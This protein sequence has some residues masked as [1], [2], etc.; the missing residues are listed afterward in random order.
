MMRPDLTHGS[1]SAKRADTDAIDVARSMLRLMLDGRTDRLGVELA[2]GTM[3]YAEGA[4]RAV[5]VAKDLA[6]LRSLVLGAESA[7][8]ARRVVEG[9]L[10]VRGDVEH[11]IAQMER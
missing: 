4:P 3:L 7:S 2:D 10:D 6:A 11:A 1:F 8:A 9:D 5:I